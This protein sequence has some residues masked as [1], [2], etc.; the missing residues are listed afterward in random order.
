MPRNAILLTIDCLRPDHLGCYGY[1]R[2]TSPNLDRLARNGILFTHAFANGPWTPLSFPS[3]L[4]SSWPLQHPPSLHLSHNHP[5][6]AEVLKDSG[7][8]TGG[9]HSN[10]YLSSFYGYNRGFDVFSDFLLS[11]ERLKQS[12]PP[13]WRLERLLKERL[14]RAFGSHDTVRTLVLNC[15]SRLR[16]IFREPDGLRRRRAEAVF[17]LDKKI[18]SAQVVNAK[19][20]SWLRETRD[21]PFFLWIHYMDV[22]LGYEPPADCLQCLAQWRCPVP[23]TTRVNALSQKVFD[24]L[25]TANNTMT[26]EDLDLM[27]DLYDAEIRYTDEQIGTLLDEVASEGLLDHTLIVVTA[28]HGEEFGEHGGLH[29]GNKLYDELLRVPLIISSPNG[30]AARVVPDLVSLLDVAPT[31]ANVLGVRT[32]EQWLGQSLIN[33]T[34]GCGEYGDGPVISECRVAGGRPAISLR[35][36]R[37]KFILTQGSQGDEVYELYDL[38]SDPGEWENLAAARPELVQQ[39]TAEVRSHLEAEKECR[40]ADGRSQVKGKIRQLKATGRL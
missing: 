7:Y 6:L 11:K 24:Y 31:I 25:Y 4:T 37:W 33:M 39:F 23:N 26:E 3:I 20:V 40:Q 34:G 10:P 38:K 30:P 36:K 19:A 12:S 32:P 22:R 29:H 14:D 18:E 5:T 17:Q 35:T 8:S 27:I 9:F 13:L 2:D 16:R 21:E 15:L 28:D 1:T